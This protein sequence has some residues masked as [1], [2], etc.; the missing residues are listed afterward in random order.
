MA[1]INECIRCGKGRWAGV[2]PVCAACR[3]AYADEVRQ[4]AMRLTTE[5]L[6][7]PEITLDELKPCFLDLIEALDG[8]AGGRHG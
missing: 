4:A 1:R 6:A 3:D 2:A 8:V 7:N 5:Y